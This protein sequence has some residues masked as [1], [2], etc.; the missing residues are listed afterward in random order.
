MEK[1]GKNCAIV[2][3][4]MYLRSFRM[5]IHSKNSTFLPVCGPDD[6]TYTSSSCVSQIFSLCISAVCISLV[7][8]GK[9]A[10]LSI[11]L[12]TCS[13]VHPWWILRLYIAVCL[14]LG[15]V[16]HLLK[17]KAYIFLLRICR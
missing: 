9:I 6:P 11:L 15:C 5:L 16:L 7:F 17:L 4:T 14:P 2:L 3:Q 10:L 12:Q 8:L 13:G 1:Q